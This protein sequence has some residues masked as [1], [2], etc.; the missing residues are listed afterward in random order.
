[1]LNVAPHP[2]AL[3]T[4]AALAT[5]CAVLSI[6]VVLR[7]W[8]FIGE[9]IGHA[10]FGGAGTAWLLAVFFPVMNNT[11]APYFTAIAF[12]TATALAIG[13]VSRSE[14]MNADATIGIFLVASLAWGFIAQQAYTQH[15]KSSPQWLE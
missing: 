11:W 5:A 8:A 4:A 6:P 2:T 9:G 13:W 7:R 10:A 1:M 3:L 12:C 15:Y 14:R